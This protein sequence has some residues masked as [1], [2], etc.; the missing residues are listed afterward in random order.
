MRWE[1]LVCARCSG[2]V[3]DGRCPACRSARES[4]SKNSFTPS[5][6]MLF[7]IIIALLVLMVIAAHH[8]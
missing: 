3:A 7:A 8:V 4:F 5:P 6:Q 2:L 1:D